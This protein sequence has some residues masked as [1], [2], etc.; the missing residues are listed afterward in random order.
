MLLLTFLISYISQ[1]LV[2]IISESSCNSWKSEIWIQIFVNV[3]PNSLGRLLC[4]HSS[5]VEGDEFSGEL[6]Q[7]IAV[8]HGEGNDLI[9]CD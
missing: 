7:L 5:T 2:N 8:V 9:L 1:L 3:L 4:S 6:W